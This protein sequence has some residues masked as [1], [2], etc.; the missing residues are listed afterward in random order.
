MLLD[1][2]HGNTP[3]YRYT[4]QG[5]ESDNEIKGEGNSINYTFRMHDPRVGRFFSVDPLMRLYPYNSPYAFSENSVIAFIELEGL[6]KYT[7]HIRSFIAGHHAGIFP[8]YF[9]GDNRDFSTHNGGFGPEGTRGATSRIKHAVEID[10]D[11]RTAQASVVSDIT[12]RT[13]PYEDRE[14]GEPESET[15]MTSDGT[16]ENGWLKIQT[17]YWGNDPAQ[18]GSPDID[19]TADIKLERRGNVLTV[20]TII[21]GDNFPSTEAFIEDT[22]E[23][24]GPGQR[25]FI[26]AFAEQGDELTLYGTDDLPL[27]NRQFSINLDEDGN[28]LSV[29]YKGTNYSIEEWNAK[30]EN[31]DASSGKGEVSP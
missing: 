4:F 31:A 27:I 19:I 15:S 5:Q 22:P 24:F 6:E 29:D 13:A 11:N 30:F 8:N 28:F 18:I 9:R 21:R 20:T 26:G 12:I 25:V 3:D 1:E 10:L 7:V 14:Y 2:R 16:S 17:K 23:Q